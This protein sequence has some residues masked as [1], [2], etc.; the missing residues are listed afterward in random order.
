VKI[1]S[2][3]SI[4]V[5][6]SP[7]LWRSAELESGPDM[8]KQRE[9]FYVSFFYSVRSQ[10][11]NVLPGSLNSLIIL[12]HAFVVMAVTRSVLRTLWTPRYNACRP[13]PSI[14][15]SP[16]PFRASM[17]GHWRASEGRYSH[18]G[19]FFFQIV[20]GPLWSAAAFR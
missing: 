17:V 3:S 9:S 5:I 8:P 11:L 13:M 4:S 18:S 2:F 1:M 10:N 20:A 19:N 6:F 7:S 16:K 14:L 15:C 12:M